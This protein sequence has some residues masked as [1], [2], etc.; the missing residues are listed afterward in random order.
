MLKPPPPIDETAR[1]MSLHSMR[2]LDTPPE[3]RFDRITRLA[4]RFFGVEICLISLVDS[5]R[6]WF[7]SKQG[8]DACETPREI[9]FCGHAILSEAALV[10][11]DASA[12]PR[13]ADNPLVTGPP[14][15]R[16]YA[17]CPIHGPY[18]HRIG[19]LC[20]IDKQPYEL[21]IE[22]RASLKDFAG[23]VEDEFSVASK[24]TVDELTQIANRR[25]FNMVAG[26]IL[27]LCKR[28]NTEAELMFFDLDDFKQVND[29]YGHQSGDKLLQ[30]FARLLIKCFR[31]ADVIA[32]LGGDEFVVLLAGGTDPMGASLT[33]LEQ[34]AAAAESPAKK[35]LAWSVGRIKF[36]TQR[37]ES[38]EA[39]LADADTSM[40]ANKSIKRGAAP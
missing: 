32:R 7:K 21:S 27:S 15:I 38:V 30:Y 14:F 4:Q 35:R 3:E 12:D 16:F 2:L 20:L 6:Q 18:G 26:H 28:T 31:S 5:H 29:T 39:L 33:R 17:G 1:L 10:V 40:Y 19:T 25:G 13:F 36:D 11:S 34:M 23:M 8:L 9:S 37:H 24:M 22:D